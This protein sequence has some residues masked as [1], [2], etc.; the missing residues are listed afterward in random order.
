MLIPKTLAVSKKK[1][2][3]RDTKQIIQGYQCINQ[4]DKRVIIDCRIY[5]SK[6]PYSSRIIA[7]VWIHDHKSQRY[8]HGVGIA[9]GYGYHKGSEAIE[10][11]LCEMGIKLDQVIGGCGYDACKKTFEALMVTMGYSSFIPAEFYA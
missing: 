7:A 1:M 8:S 2:T 3:F 9:G 11:A 5:A 4:E 10:R 6:R